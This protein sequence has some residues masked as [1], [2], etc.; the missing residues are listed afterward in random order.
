MS[1]ESSS[2]YKRKVGNTM[3]DQIAMESKEF[4]KKYRNLQQLGRVWHKYKMKKKGCEMRV[5][6]GLLYVSKASPPPHFT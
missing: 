6:G 1:F 2:K 4:W 5:R 3:N